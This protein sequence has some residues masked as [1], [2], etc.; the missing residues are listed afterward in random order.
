MGPRWL[1]VESR[2]DK[3]M[4]APTSAE[5][6]QVE[7]PSEHR[8]QRLSS[9]GP[10]EVKEALEYARPRSWADQPVHAQTVNLHCCCCG[11]DE[12]DPDMTT[13]GP[14]ME[15]VKAQKSSP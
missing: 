9:K 11:G 2:T 15:E 12:I 6:S 7:K 8:M 5:A 10:E 3:D 13:N 4:S 14:P 1:P